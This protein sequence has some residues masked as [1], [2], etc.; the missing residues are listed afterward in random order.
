[1]AIKVSYIAQGSDDYDDDSESN[2]YIRAIQN[3]SLLLDQD[4]YIR[5]DTDVSGGTITAATIEWYDDAF[6][7]VGRTTTYQG[8]LS[9]SS[10]EG[11]VEIYSF[12]SS[13]A[14][15]TGW[16]SYDLTSGELGNINID[17]STYFRFRCD[18]PGG[19]NSRSWDVRAYEY[20][21]SH[22][23]RAK[24]TLEYT[25]PPP[26]PT[27]KIIY[28]DPDA[29]G[30]ADG[31]SWTD[32]YTSL[33]TAVSSEAEDITSAGSDEKHYYYC[34]SSNETADGVSTTAINFAGY[35]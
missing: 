6:T 24:L 7:K 22:T 19:S 9:V 35:V 5:L 20:D 3:P 16:K 12:D 25:E 1:M 14:P 34:R 21:V 33:H 30:S 27:T 17:G 23:Y 10:D 32:A 2:T 8:S 4:A 11:Y 31:T 13:S 28:V 15:S 29:V 18:N 26:E